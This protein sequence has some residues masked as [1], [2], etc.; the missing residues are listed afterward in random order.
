MKIAARQA[1]MFAALG[2][3]ASNACTCGS[4]GGTELF[5]GR[6]AIAPDVLDFGT[7]D[8]SLGGNVQLVLTNAGRAPLTIKNTM[9][10]ANLI[11]EVMLDAIPAHLDVGAMAPVNAV[12]L[13]KARG[14]RDGEIVFLTDSFETEIVHLRVIAQAVEP[15]LIAEPPAVDF[16]RIVVGETATATVSIENAGDSPIMIASVTPDVGTS[17]AFQSVLGASRTLMPGEMFPLAIAYTPPIRGFDMGRIVIDDDTHAPMRLGIDVKGEGITSEIDVDPLSLDFT[18]LLLGERSSRPFWIRN[19][20]GH[21]HT[22][23][24][25]ALTSTSSDQF[26]ISTGTVSAPFDLMPGAAQEVDVTY[27]PH[28]TMLHMGRVI[29]ASSDLGTSV[30]VMLTGGAI[31]R[32]RPQIAVSP[33]ALYFGAVQAGTASVRHVTIENVGLADLHL[34]GDVAVDPPTAPFAL[35]DVPATNATL[36]ALDR[37]TIGIAY[38]PAAGMGHVLASLVIASDDPSMAVIRV[39]LDGDVTDSPIAHVEWMPDEIVFGALPRFGGFRRTLLFE[40]VGSLPLAI[41]GASWVDGANGLFILDAQSSFP[42]AVPPNASWKFSILALDGAA[43]LFPATSRLRFFTNDPDRP[44]IDMT[45]SRDVIAPSPLP[46]A[47]AADLAWDAANADLD[48]HLL[49]NGGAL[50]DAPSDACW[51]NP[52]PDWGAIADTTD[53]PIVSR[54]ALAAGLA[55]QIALLSAPERYEVLVHFYSDHGSGAAAS[56]T[57]TI[58]MT[59]AESATFSRAM[60]RDLVWDVGTFDGPTRSFTPIGAPLSS[61]VRAMCY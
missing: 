29:V 28:D 14:P 16:G 55:E 43:S 35:S 27:A 48:L 20:G 25:I 17:A 54:D 34:L 31:G 47:F 36:N 41:N 60:T 61:A 24:R 13:P 10:S 39:P 12:F 2:A 33:Q 11:R 53:D 46:P 42:I 7:V 52:A 15:R 59:G 21:A 19:I 18:G 5:D 3:L 51:C 38:L 22:I 9:V 26:S 8:V 37:R 45:V 4:G 58:A 56:A 57:V 23:S 50:F 32:P 6:L 44:T 40:S 49:R 1:R 30:S